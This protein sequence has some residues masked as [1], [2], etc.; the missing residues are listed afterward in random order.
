MAQG[1][2]YPAL[3]L[4]VPYADKL[5]R[6]DPS[7]VLP[8]WMSRFFLYA[9][10]PPPRT[11]IDPLVSPALAS[12]EVIRQFPPTV[13]L[14]AAYDYLAYEAEEF[15]ARLRSEGVDVQNQRFE[16]VGHGF[17]GI[18]TYNKKRRML[19]HAARD[20]AWGLIADIFQRVLH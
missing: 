19:N 1:L 10:L 2:L 17:D 8:Q 5:A 20:R 12:D 9:Y 3:N 14:T 15:A 18:P 13:I 11:A 6:V 4:A 16:D 7:H